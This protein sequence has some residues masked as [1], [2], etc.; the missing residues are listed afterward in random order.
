LSEV[1][2]KF[3]G[4]PEALDRTLASLNLLTNSL[5]TTASSTDPLVHSLNKV[6]APL[7]ETSESA[8]S[9]HLAIAKLNQDV[10]SLSRVI[11]TS[12]N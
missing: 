12:S 11:A 10:E 4:V 9:L 6:N 7:N 5:A 1:S 8:K 3:N 2:L